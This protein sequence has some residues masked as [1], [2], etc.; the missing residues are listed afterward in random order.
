MRLM[1]EKENLKRL[2]KAPFTTEH[3]TILEAFLADLADVVPAVGEIASLVRIV[4][5][6]E[7]KDDIR[8]AMEVGDLVAG[9]PPGIGDALDVL[10][11][12]NT[13]LYLRRKG[14][15]LE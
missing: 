13:L 2:V 11:P 7:K 5:A 4:E 1:G 12:T 14:F 8:A 9:I 15:K 6:I 10:T 3:E